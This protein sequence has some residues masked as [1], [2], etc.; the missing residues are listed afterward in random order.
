MPVKYHIRLS[1]EEQQ[2]LKQVVRAKKMARYKR[3]HA[4]IL[5]ALDENGPRLSE[6]ATAAT[7]VTSIKTVQRIRKR[8][9]EEGLETAIEGK[10]KH[11]GRSPILDGEQHA[12]LV[13]LA[14]SKPPEGACRWTM[15]LLANKM[16]ELD[17]VDSIS[18]PTVCREL[19]KT[20]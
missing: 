14:C 11:N 8:C 4:Q 3:T 19:K 15:K 17:I 5:L 10:I 18:A 1:N 7:C 16:I 6:S 20:K 9:V 12:H 13:A 2:T